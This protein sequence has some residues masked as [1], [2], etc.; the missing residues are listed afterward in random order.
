MEKEFKTYDEMINL[1]ERRGIIFSDESEKEYA[2]NVLS[3]VGYYNIINGYSKLFLE[4][5]DPEKY[6]PGV[7]F[8]EIHALYQFDA[9]L[10]QIFFKYILILET[11]MKSLISYSFSK[12]HGH[13]NYLVYDNFNRKGKN[14]TEKIVSLIAEIE[15]Q[16]AG[17]VKDPCISHYLA[18]Y[19]YI[20]LWVLNNILTFGTIS[21]FYSL[22]KTEE[23]QEISKPLGLHD[24]ELE[25]ALF[26]L[27]SIRN[28]C[29]HGN[30][31]YCYRTKNPLFDSY[32]HEKMKLKKGP[33]GEYSVGKRDLFAAMIALR[34]LLSHNDFRKLCGEI[35]IAIGALDKKLSVLK[36][37]DI[38]AE[39]GFPNNWRK[40]A[41]Y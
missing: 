9:S 40:V 5:T 15:K 38:L 6:K 1:L 8:R 13:K 35:Y 14:N 24:F 25:N 2:K 30:R 36:R 34:K 16:I 37:S 11:N 26:Y 39:M 27:T 12:V 31:L 33:G 29:A 18:T 22:M 19:G 20:P 7:T 23:R 4:P 41:N 21:K 32:I 28:F 3:K 17:R 10:R